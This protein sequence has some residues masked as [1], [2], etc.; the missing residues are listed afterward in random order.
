M[1]YRMVL[2]SNV[3]TK[4]HRPIQTLHSPELLVGQKTEKDDFQ[5]KGLEG[6]C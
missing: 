6:L 2:L 3:F 5:Q 1:C 4:T